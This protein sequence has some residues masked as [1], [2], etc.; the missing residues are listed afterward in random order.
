M[1]LKVLGLYLNFSCVELHPEQKALSKRQPRW[2]RDIFSQSKNI[3]FC[4]PVVKVVSVDPKHSFANGWQRMNANNQLLLAQ[5]L[6]AFARRTENVIPTVLRLD[7]TV[8]YI[9]WRVHKVQDAPGN[10]V[11]KENWQRVKAILYSKEKFFP[12]ALSL[13]TGIF[14]KNSYFLDY[15]AIHQLFLQKANSRENSSVNT[16]SI[17]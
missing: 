17:S 3:G 4:F 14:Q 15:L 10:F 1:T 16:I 7:F 6:M 12:M 8:K 13:L 5:K 11:M 9:A 2:L